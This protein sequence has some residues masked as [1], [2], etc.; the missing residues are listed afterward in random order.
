MNKVIIHMKESALDSV[1]ELGLD[2]KLND[3]EVDV[4]VDDIEYNPDHDYIDPDE[5]FVFEYGLDWEQ[6]NCVELA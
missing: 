5:Q 2:Y 1:K 6:V 4:I 3:N